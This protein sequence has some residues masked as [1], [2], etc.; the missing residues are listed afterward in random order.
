[1]FTLLVSTYNFL[2]CF[3]NFLRYKGKEDFNI[4]FNLENKNKIKE[5]NEE[6]KKEEEII[7][8]NKNNND[9]VGKIF[10]IKINSIQKVR[11]VFFMLFCFMFFCF[12]L[13]FLLLFFLLLFFLFLFFLLLFFFSSF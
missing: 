7:I 10:Q 2:C 9:S 8:P 5:K 1:M 4:K 12:M 3:I 13:F 11:F 6:L